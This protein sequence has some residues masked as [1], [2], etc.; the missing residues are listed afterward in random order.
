MSVKSMISADAVYKNF[1]NKKEYEKKYDE[2]KHCKLL[3]E[4][5]TD[6]YKGTVSAYCVAAMICME[7]FYTWVHKYQMFGQ[8]YQ[9][10]K[11]IA[12]EI[13]EEEG[14]RLK[15][16]ERPIGVIDNEFEHWKF[17][18]WSKFGISKNPKLR[19]PFKAEN[20]AL[21][22]YRTIMRQASE[23][24]FT[25]SEFKQLMEAINV[26]LNVHQVMN[27]QSQIDELKSDLSKMQENSNG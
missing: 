23:G 21:D 16:K 27:M 1:K 10:S 15:G 20:N 24:D 5:M 22:H 2:E 9:F 19:I 6:S 13:W 26:G 7:T 25:A 12:R 14:H 17:I 3:I 11:L 4:V 8:I 18:G